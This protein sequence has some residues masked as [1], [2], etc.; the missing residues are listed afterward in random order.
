MSV[1][2]FF[3]IIVFRFLFYHHF[4]KIWRNEQK[5]KQ[6]L[7][8]HLILFLL[9]L[10]TWKR[11]IFFPW[12]LGHSRPF[13]KQLKSWSHEVFSPLCLL[14]YWSISCFHELLCMLDTSIFFYLNVLQIALATLWL[15][16]SI[17]LQDIL[18]IR[19]VKNIVTINF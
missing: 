9:E 1:F 12:G 5:L 14:N 8:Y 13:M 18:I 17:T 4:N 6:Y 3:N 10:Y 11:S 7:F 2:V 15:V 19:V 16:F